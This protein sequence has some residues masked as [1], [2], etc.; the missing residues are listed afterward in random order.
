MLD[1]RRDYG[2]VRNAN[3]KVLGALQHIVNPQVTIT[4]PEAELIEDNQNGK[5]ST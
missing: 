4:V 5:N 2:T 3:E 1:V